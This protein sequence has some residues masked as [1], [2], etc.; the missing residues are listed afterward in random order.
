MINTITKK[1]KFTLTD[2]EYEILE[3]A[4]DIISNM[5]DVA[6]SIDSSVFSDA[7]IELDTIIEGVDVIDGH[8]VYE[9]EK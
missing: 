8:L 9:V 1:V 3:K 2:E 5:D 7:Y 6:S 4:R